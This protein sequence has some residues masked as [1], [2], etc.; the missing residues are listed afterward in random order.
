MFNPATVNTNFQATVYPVG[1]SKVRSLYTR[2]NVSNSTSFFCC[3]WSRIRLHTSYKCTKFQ[4]NRSTGLRVRANFVICAKRRRK[5]RKW[6]S[7]KL[8]LWLPVTLTQLW[9]VTSCYKWALQQQIWWSLDKRSWI[10]ECIKIADFF[11]F[12]LIHSFSIV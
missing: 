12:L 9:N 8:K 4:P 5:R 10:N 7:K 3:F 1:M 6:Q 11:L 2:I